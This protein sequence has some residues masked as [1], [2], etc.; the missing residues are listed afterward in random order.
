MGND[1]DDN[2]RDRVYCWHIWRITSWCFC[3]GHCE[4]CCGK[5]GCE[6]YRCRHVSM[7]VMKGLERRGSNN[8]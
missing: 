6:C 5:G 8:K 7:N 3:C 1:Y 2:K 4:E